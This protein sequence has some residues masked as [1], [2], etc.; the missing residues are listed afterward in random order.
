[1][2]QL[3]ADERVY[4]AYWQHEPS[5]LTIAKKQYQ[6]MKE[7]MDE[8]AAYR[9]AVEYV[10]DIENNSYEELLELKKVLEDSQAVDSF[11]S[12]PDSL[13]FISYWKEKLA[14]TEYTDLELADQG[15]IDHFIQTKVLRWNEIERERRMKDPMFF[16]NFQEVREAIFPNVSKSIKAGDYLIPEDMEKFKAGVSAIYDEKNVSL[17][18][19][20]APFYFEDY[21]RYFEMAKN[22]PVLSE[23]SQEDQ[24]EF[25]RWISDTLAFSVVL[26]TA[27][28][29]V[30]KEYL[31]SVRN[32]FFPMLHGDEQ[33]DATEGKTSM[34]YILPDDLGFRTVLYKHDIGY[35]REDEKL[36]VKRFYHIPALLFPEESENEQIVKQVQ[37]ALNELRFGVDIDFD[38]PSSTEFIGQSLKYESV[39]D[40]VLNSEEDSK[41]VSQLHA[42][43]RALSNHQ[44]DAATEHKTFSDTLLHTK[45]DSMD[46]KQ[47]ALERISRATSKDIYPQDNELIDKEEHPQAFNEL[48]A[49]HYK[50]PRTRLQLERDLW[51]SQVEPYDIEDAKDESDILSIT[52]TRMDQQLLTR[53]ELAIKYDDKEAARRSRDWTGRL[54]PWEKQMKKGVKKGAQRDTLD[55]K[56]SLPT[57]A[58]DP[59]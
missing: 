14:T 37:E 55:M 43:L 59:Y 45:D 33:Q 39:V 7:G 1:M 44:Q 48:L 50:P 2:I 46:E 41:A 57:S 36:Y 25:S 24:E 42:D 40:K 22:Q 30:V 28:S 27:P 23:W 49:K 19:T 58:S 10:D 4:P 21:C 38:E 17:W 16:M 53:A 56:L 52:G 8:E 6:H 5:A 32:N 15:E 51:F 3:Y 26:Q 35:K 47:Q 11:V 54:I 12:D 31:K 18:K 9:K 29:S 34:D 13:N 20:A